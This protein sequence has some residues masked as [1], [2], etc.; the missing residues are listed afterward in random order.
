M[1]IAVMVNF[2]PV[3]H[4]ATYCVWVMVERHRGHWMSPTMAQ[5]L[6]RRCKY[7]SFPS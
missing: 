3:F 5:D 6:D 7:K 1:T 4:K 2:V